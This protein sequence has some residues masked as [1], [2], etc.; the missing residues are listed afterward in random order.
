MLLLKF[1]N[2]IFFL[3]TLGVN[4]FTIGGLGPFKSISNISNTYQTSLTPPSWAFSI[5]GLIYF[6]LL[7]FSIGQFIPKLGL[8]KYI[9]NINNLFIISCILNITWLLIFSLGTKESILSSVF[10]IFALLIVLLV[11]QNKCKFFN[12]KINASKFIFL[13]LPFSL[14]LGWIIFA[15]LANVA[16]CVKA[17]MPIDNEFI[18]YSLLFLVATLFY[19]SNLYFSGNY[20]TQ[21]VYFY[22]CV[23]F[24]S[25]YY[26]NNKLL[27]NFT[28]GTLFFSVF[29]TL[30]KCILDVSWWKKIKNNNMF[31]PILE[32]KVEDV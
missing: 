7:L 24:L 15:S 8:D 12:E 6:G 23:A 5:W 3:G 21:L 4:Y 30:I 27:F 26:Q 20:I 17:W 11:I 29:S 19:I 1:L 18:F 9:K 32:N 10:I 25:K 2:L 31:E 22:V 13:V 16:I 28:I 14:Y